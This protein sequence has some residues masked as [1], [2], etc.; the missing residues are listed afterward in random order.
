MLECMPDT[1]P[2]SASGSDA[3][4]SVSSFGF[5]GSNAFAVVRA[6][7][8][9]F[10][11]VRQAQAEPLTLRKVPFFASAE[12]LQ[13]TIWVDFASPLRQQIG[14]VVSRISLEA[15]QNW[16]RIIMNVWE[17]RIVKRIPI[18]YFLDISV[19]CFTFFYQCSLFYNLIMMSFSLH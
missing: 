5:G 1:R 9:G 12:L 14:E 13:H 15:C 18:I 2:R 7:P 3:I 8:L 11:S 6:I 4:F 16:G 17:R 10:N 19:L